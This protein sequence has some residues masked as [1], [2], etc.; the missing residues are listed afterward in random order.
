MAEDYML[1]M[2]NKL[3]AA[4]DR[5]KQ[6]TEV[7]A[8]KASAPTLFEIIDGEISLVVN[9]MT[10]EKALSYDDYLSK[11]GQVR[12]ILKIRNLLDSKEAEAFAAKQEVTALEQN[13]KQIQDDKKQK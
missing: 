9:S 12:G 13:I 8:L 2:H 11:H 7:K 6:G 10:Q 3:E 4:R 5:L 1:Q